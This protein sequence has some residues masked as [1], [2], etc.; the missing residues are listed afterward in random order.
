MTSGKVFRGHWSLLPVTD[1]CSRGRP[2]RYC[3]DP[4]AWDNIAADFGDRA[5]CQ[6]GFIDWFGEP[7]DPLLCRLAAEHSLD[8]H[9]VLYC[10][11]LNYKPHKTW[12]DDHVTA[13][14]KAMTGADVSSG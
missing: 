7:V 14:V 2:G 8:P 10:D 13:V 5:F 12:W 11:G 3:C 9:Q 1:A 4:A 6:G